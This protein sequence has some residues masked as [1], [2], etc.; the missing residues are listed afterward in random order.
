MPLGHDALV[1]TM[2]VTND[3][4][5]EITAK[6]GSTVNEESIKEENGRL[7]EPVIT[8]ERKVEDPTPSDSDDNQVDSKASGKSDETIVHDTLLQ[9]ITGETEERKEDT[10]ND[11]TDNDA[12]QRLSQAELESLDTIPSEIT[13]TPSDEQPS[14]SRLESIQTEEVSPTTSV[15]LND[16]AA[17]ADDVVSVLDEAGSAEHGSPLVSAVATE[18]AADVSELAADKFDF[19]TL[20]SLE[21]GSEDIHE[22]DHTSIAPSEPDTDALAVSIV[23]LDHAAGIVEAALQED[24]LH[25]FDDED[26]GP[27]AGSETGEKQE[28]LVLANENSNHNEP[29][30]VVAPAVVGSDADLVEGLLQSTADGVPS[31][32]TGAGANHD[33]QEVDGSRVQSDLPEIIQPPVEDKTESFD[34]AQAT[35]PTEVPQDKVIEEAP[36]VDNV[37]EAE[38]DVEAQLQPANLIEAD[39]EEVVKPVEPEV[40][41]APHETSAAA[42]TSSLEETEK[43]STPIVAET[44]VEVVGVEPEVVETQTESDSG[45][46]IED[47]EPKESEDTPVHN[48]IDVNE[49]EAP[50]G[51]EVVHEESSSVDIENSIGAAAKEHEV[52]AE[53]TTGISEEGIQHVDVTATEQI[54]EEGEVEKPP[55]IEVSSED[56]DA[57]PGSLM[58]L[59]SDDVSEKFESEPEVLSSQTLIATKESEDIVPNQEEAGLDSSVV[60]D[61]VITPLAQKDIIE[62]TEAQEGQDELEAD[63]KEESHLVED[64]V[65]A[66][67]DIPEVD[68][69]TGT[70]GAETNPL[71][72]DEDIDPNT[73]LEQRLAEAVGIPPEQLASLP[74]LSKEAV[75]IPGTS[76]PIIE[77]ELKT[78]VQVEED[79]ETDKELGATEA[80]QVSKALMKLYPLLTEISRGTVLRKSLSQRQE[81]S[82]Q[83]WS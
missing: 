73:P 30:D 33:E 67:D 45:D 59:L 27:L 7:P 32:E 12:V 25:G 70:P 74:A 29:G 20:N 43:T 3:E 39:E 6:A 18:A 54:A 34:A 55:A 72:V 47:S 69:E 62:N 60:E 68:V 13:V 81:V 9:G 56:I 83:D 75:A 4:S 16:P 28:E 37:A 58:E 8:G 2:D 76:V 53:K 51:S 26:E 66:A 35:A 80:G 52:S 36:L 79:K 50:S 40:Q 77:E 24:D 10:T 22:D 48:L 78:P 63:I 41:A 46:V 71:D 49:E 64:V 5:P 65:P 23:G 57:A 38:K 14:L 19:S 11:K 21:T 15:I 1:H 82:L 42:V 61:V 44:I 31:E 17:A